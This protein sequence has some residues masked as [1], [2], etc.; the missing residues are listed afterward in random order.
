MPSK[1]SF[2]NKTLFRKNLSRFW[3]LWGG[4][5]L[6]GAMFPLY[7]ALFLM[8]VQRPAE[9]FSDGFF[10]EVLYTVATAAVPAITC[11]YAIFCAMASPESA[12]VTN[13]HVRSTGS[14]CIIPA[15]RL[16]QR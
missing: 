14:A 5:S 6:V 13:R 16:L 15:D 11:I 4:L 10:A 7:M 9:D 3:P 2:F 12:L 1:S 8:Q